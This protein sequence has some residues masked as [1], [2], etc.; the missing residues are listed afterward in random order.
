M[1]GHNQQVVLPGFD[2]S[3]ETTARL[4]ILTGLVEEWTRKIN[5]VSAS[6][7][8][9]MAVRH[10]QDSAQLM[11]FAPATARRWADLGSGG[12]FPG[13]VIAIVAHELRPQLAVTLVESDQRKATFLR[14]AARE[15]GVAVHIIADRIERIPPLRCDVLSARAL[16]PLKD[17]LEFAE[18]HL[19]P[20]GCAIFPKGRRAEAEI[21]KAR[22]GW[23]FDMTSTP[24]QTDADA[25]ILSIRGI[26]RA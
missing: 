17:L 20:S 12:G 21:A 1:Q 7:I 23:N 10:V 5:L 8:S 9:D 19:E 13:L 14:V 11:C 18:R 26:H 3:R 4:A 24:S 22:K 25:V 2:V 15:V 6:S 16:A